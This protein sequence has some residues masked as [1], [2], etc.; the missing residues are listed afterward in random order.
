MGR[1]SRRPHVLT[2]L[3]VC[4][5]FA[6]FPANATICCGFSSSGSG[7]GITLTASADGAGNTTSFSGLETDG[8]T[9]QTGL[10]QGCSDLQGMGWTEATSLWGCTT[11]LTAN[12][13]TAT[14]D[15]GSITAD[16]KEVDNAAAASTITV[17][18][19]ATGES[20]ILGVPTAAANAATSSFTCRVSGTNTVTVR[21][22]CIGTCDPGS[23]SFK[24][25]VPKL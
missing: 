5:A 16:C 11:F 15:F 1:L 24:A 22:C 8:T 18:G 17:T 21:H 12:S 13:G 3:L 9:G 14:I 4:L 23:G 19:A 7:S 20:C 6:V 25:V 2:V 10:L